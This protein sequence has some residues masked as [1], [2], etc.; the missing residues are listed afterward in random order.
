MISKEQS[1]V[2]VVETIE[3]WIPSGSSS[4][5]NTQLRLSIKS[6]PETGINVSLSSFHSSNSKLYFA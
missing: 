2:R 3:E 6:N 1:A 5:N 4:W